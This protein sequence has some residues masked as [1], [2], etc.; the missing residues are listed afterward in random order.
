MNILLKRMV[1]GISSGRKGEMVYRGEIPRITGSIKHNCAGDN[2]VSARAQKN[3][4][5]LFAEEY[6]RLP[7]ITK[8]DN[9]LTPQQRDQAIKDL[10]GSSATQ[11]PAAKMPEGQK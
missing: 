4:T 10:Q 9:L 1:A 8:M 5:R 7:E 6:P 3:A 11:A 2:P